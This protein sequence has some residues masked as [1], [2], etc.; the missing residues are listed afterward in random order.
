MGQG[1][2]TMT[3]FNDLGFGKFGSNID[4]FANDFFFH[5]AQSFLDSGVNNANKVHDAVGDTAGAAAHAAKGVGDGLHDVG[6]A[7]GDIAKQ[8]S[9][10][11]P[12]AA[13]GFGAIMLMNALK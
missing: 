12:Y 9:Q 2:Y 8:L 1:I 11:M 3:F 5:P 10:I 4:N 13:M 6:E 7:G